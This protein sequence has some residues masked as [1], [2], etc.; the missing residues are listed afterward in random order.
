MTTITDDA[1]KDLVYALMV[2]EWPGY[3]ACSEVLWDS[4]DEFEHLSAAE[5][6]EVIDRL[7]ALIR[8]ARVTITFDEEV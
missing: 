7:T 8:K 1:L 3:L 6:E 4:I 2:E 5:Q